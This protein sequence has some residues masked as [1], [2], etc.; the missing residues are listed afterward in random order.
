MNNQDPV[1]RRLTAL[2]A[3]ALAIA[4]MGSMLL[5]CNSF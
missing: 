4:I 5:L 3:F 2:T 1:I